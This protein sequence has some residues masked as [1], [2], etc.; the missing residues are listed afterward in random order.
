MVRKSRGGDFGAAK[1][2]ADAENANTALPVD[3]VTCAPV[4]PPTAH[5][6]DDVPPVNVERPET[7]AQVIAVRSPFAVI[8]TLDNEPMAET[9]AS[10]PA[11]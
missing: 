6:T 5:K 1:R 7:V 3:A 2:D 11:V 9:S 8:P 4:I 10:P